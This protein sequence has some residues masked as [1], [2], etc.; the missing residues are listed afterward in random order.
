MCVYVCVCVCVVYVLY[1]CVCHVRCIDSTTQYV[2]KHGLLTIKTF[3]DGGQ[4]LISAYSLKFHSKEFVW[5]I[6][7][8]PCLCHTHKM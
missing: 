4:M 8:Q 5:V 7:R 2:C 6:V 3:Q 1:V